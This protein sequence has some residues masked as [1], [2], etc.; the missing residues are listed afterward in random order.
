[1]AADS[2]TPPRDNQLVDRLEDA[3]FLF[4]LFAGASLVIAILLLMVVL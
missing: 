4:T 3:A 1:M 2:E